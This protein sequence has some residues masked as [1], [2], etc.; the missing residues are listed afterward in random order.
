MGQKSRV[1]KAET[2]EEYEK[3]TILFEKREKTTI[4]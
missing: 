2:D 3:A 1:R 4:L